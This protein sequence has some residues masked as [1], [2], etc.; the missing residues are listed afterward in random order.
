MTHL[1]ILGVVVA[2]SVVWRWF[3]RLVLIYLTAFAV[4]YLG[5]S[6]WLHQHPEHVTTPPPTEVAQ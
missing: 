6:W 1:A 4:G 5:V 3:R 2:L